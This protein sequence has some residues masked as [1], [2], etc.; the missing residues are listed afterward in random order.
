MTKILLFKTSIHN[1]ILIKLFQETCIKS[2]IDNSYIFNN[3][4]YK[5]GIFNQT[6][7][8]FIETCKEHYA[9]SK[10]H[11]LERK[12]SYNYFITI[13]R[14]IC[15]HNKI[16][17]TSK[18]LYDKSDYNITYYFYPITIDDVSLT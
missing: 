18:I 13:L 12:L 9:P 10:Q 15:K 16:K 7:S 6:I 5:R 14:Q 1:S 3:D 11:Y 4:S 17:Y 8:K 2:E